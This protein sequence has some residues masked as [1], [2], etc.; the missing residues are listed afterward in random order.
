MQSPQDM[1]RRSR[2][3]DLHNAALDTPTLKIRVFE[4][5]PKQAP[6]IGVNRWRY[7]GKARYRQ[8]FTSERHFSRSKGSIIEECSY[9]SAYTVIESYGCTP[10]HSGKIIGIPDEIAGLGGV[11]ASGPIHVNNRNGVARHFL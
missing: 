7:D 4:H 2:L 1:F 8:R 9:H 3:A 6:V 11:C 5:F 10:A